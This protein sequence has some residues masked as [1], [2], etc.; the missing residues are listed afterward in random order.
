MNLKKLVYL[1]R[2]PAG[3]LGGLPLVCP[4]KALPE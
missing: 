1:F 3:P 4:N 2:K